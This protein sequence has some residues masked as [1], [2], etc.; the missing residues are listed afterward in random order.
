MGDR[1]V[2]T[3]SRFPAVAA[4]VGATVV[5]GSTF[6][7]T[8]H[9]L[10]DMAAALF[11]TWRFGLAA[12]VLL[13]APGRVRALSAKE[14]RR[15]LLLGTLLGSGFLLQ[16]VGLKDTPAGVS[17]FLTGT[18]VMLT[19]VVAAAFFA[20]RVGRAG[21]MAVVVCGAGLALLADGSP[22]LSPGALLTLGGA[23]LCWAHYRAQPVGHPIE[24]IRFDRVE[25]GRGCPALR[26]RRGPRSRAGCSSQR[27][28]VAVCCLPGSRRDL[29]GLRSTGLG[30]EH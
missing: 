21:W 3:A 15:G 27:R 1:S 12:L 16:T 11:L 22:A 23:R 29:H 18:A 26:R 20:D 9:S 8:K 2:D 13:T 28:C 25:C 4:L 19:P 24:R 17:G 5:W 6:V 14:W 10:T 30:A 7:V